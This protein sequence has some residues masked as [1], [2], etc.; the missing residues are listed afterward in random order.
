[1]YLEIGTSRLGWEI[2]LRIVE[3]LIGNATRTRKKARLKSN[4]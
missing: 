1:M 3:D 4:T 2:E